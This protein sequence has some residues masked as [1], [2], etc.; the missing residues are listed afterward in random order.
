MKKILALSLLSIFSIA[1]GNAATTPWWLQ[2]TICRLSPTNCYSS[3]GIGFD[4][5]M[6]DATSNCRGL[7]LICPD[8]LTSGGRD[9]VPMGRAE[10]AKGTGINADFDTD[11]LGA[12]GDC[13]GRRK[14]A[15]DGA[16]ASVNGKYVPVWCNGILIKPDET[17]ANGEITYD[18]QPTC[19]V[20]ANDGFIAIENGRCYG[21]YYNP[22][23]YYI[24]CNGGRDLL[25]ARII[26]LNG[27][28][29]QNATQDIPTT[30]ADADAIFDEMFRLSQQQKEQYFKT[31]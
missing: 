1:S 27:T 30:M 13:F 16:M 10:I 23:E 5:E 28:D 22:N 26:V 25:P 8:A 29:I 14:T 15:E 31:E 12:D 24:D 9:A 19:E 21:K 4:T 11:L 6:W 20:L 7:K 17:L 3:M 18:T 2:P